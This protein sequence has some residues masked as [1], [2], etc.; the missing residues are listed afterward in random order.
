M[1]AVF[2][3]EKKTIDA[4]V[5]KYKNLAAIRLPKKQADAFKDS[6]DK[7]RTGATGAGGSVDQQAS[8]ERVKADRTEQTEQVAA[9]R[10]KMALQ[11]IA[12]KEKLDEIKKSVADG[13]TTRKQGNT[14]GNHHPTK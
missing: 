11:K 8:A 2:N 3:D 9:Q 6:L 13:L 4:L 7:I 12:D 1:E 10:Q 5:I 14:A